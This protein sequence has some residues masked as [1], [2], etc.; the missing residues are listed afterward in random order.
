MSVLIKVLKP[1][2]EKSNEC[3]HVSGGK[4][5]FPKYKAFLSESSLNKS[6]EMKNKKLLKL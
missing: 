2:L 3:C 5:F 6:S 4:F 1:V